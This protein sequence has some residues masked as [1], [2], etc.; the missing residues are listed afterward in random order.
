LDTNDNGRRIPGGFQK[1]KM[2]VNS[3]STKITAHMGNIKQGI[4]YGE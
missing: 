1:I 4:L 2:P 3:N